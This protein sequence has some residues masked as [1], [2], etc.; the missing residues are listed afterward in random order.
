M[1]EYVRNGCWGKVI[2]LE[3]NASHVRKREGR[4]EVWCDK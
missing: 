3:I 4:C 2:G 1:P